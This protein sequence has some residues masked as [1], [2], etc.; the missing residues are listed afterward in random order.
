MGADLWEEDVKSKTDE[1]I[2]LIFISTQALST[3]S[4]RG[5]S[6]LLIH[7]SSLPCLSAAPR[8][9][10]AVR[11]P[12]GVSREP[13]PV[14]GSTSATLPRSRAYWQLHPQGRLQA[15]TKAEAGPGGWKSQ[16]AIACFQEQC[17]HNLQATVLEAV[18]H[19]KL[20]NV[21]LCAP[22]FNPQS[23]SV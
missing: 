19:G 11:P 3:V 16:C 18:C 12:T 13:E 2:R 17:G 9:T 14:G 10:G 1:N 7:M 4:T 15:H 5:Q 21:I 22:C 20:H 6:A 23:L 8:Y